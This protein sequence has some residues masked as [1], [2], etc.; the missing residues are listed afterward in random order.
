MTTHVVPLNEAIQAYDEARYDDAIERLAPLVSENP[1]DPQLRF[2]LANACREAGL[3][4]E[5]MHHFEEVLKLT[6]DQKL[7]FTAR[8][9]LAELGKGYRREVES[10]PTPTVPEIPQLVP[11]VASSPGY[12]A[13]WR[14]TPLIPTGKSSFFQRFSLRTKATLLAVA[15]GLIPIVAIGSLAYKFADNA[16]T[17]KVNQGQVD[18]AKT[19]SN[20][21]SLF[22]LERFGDIQALS[23][24]PAFT[25]PRMQKMITGTEKREFLESYMKYNSYYDSIVV[26]DLAG[27][28][29]LETGTGDLKSYK[30]SDYFQAVLKNSKPIISSPRRSRG[31]GKFSIYVAAPLIDTVTG[32]VIGVIRTRIPQENIQQFLTRVTDAHFFFVNAEGIIFS[33][34]D[35]KN[36]GQNLSEVVPGIGFLSKAKV[37]SSAVLMDKD[38]QSL[39]AY[40]PSIPQKG[41][42]E[43][44]WSTVVAVDTKTAYTAQNQLLFTLLVG[45]GLTALLVSITAATVANRAIVPIL[46]ATKAVQ[47]LGEGDL[48]VRL[49]V[50][51]EDEIALLGNNINGMAGQLQELLAKQEWV[52]QVAITESERQ[53]LLAT[54]GSAPAR[55]IEDL[56][57]VLNQLLAGPQKQLHLDRLVIYV[58]K[59]DGSGFVVAE[60]V[61]PGWPLAL[62]DTI[63]DRVQDPC[64]AQERIAFYRTGGVVANHNL[65]ESGYCEEHHQLL[66]RLKVKANLIVPLL[67]SG[68]VR[69]LL[70][71]HNCTKPHRWT[72]EEI[73]ELQLLAAQL[74]PITER[75]SYLEQ[76]DYSRALA[77]TVSEEQRAQTEALQMQLIT[78]LDEVEGAAQGDL[79]VRANVTAGE[80]GIVGD[81]FNAIIENLRKIVTQVKTS[82]ADL[83]TSLGD[84][85]GSMRSLAEDANRQADEISRTLGSVEYMTLSIQEVAQSARQAAIVAKN[86]SITAAEGGLSMD[87]TVAGILD[88]R[89]TVAETSKKVKRLGESSQKISK[90]VSLINQIALQT[91]V[92]AINASIEAAR[93][94]EEGRGFAVVA[95]EVGALATRS[96]AATREIEQL[97]ENIQSETSEVVDAMAT[98]TSQVVEGTRLVEE[99]K[100]SLKQIQEVS[101]QIDDLVGRISD[102]T[103]SQTQTSQAVTTL[104]KQI[105]A[106]AERSSEASA[107]VS[108]S[109]RQTVQV[110]QDL[111]R[112]V[113]YFKIP[114]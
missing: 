100:K 73:E 34:N 96:A 39:V 3:L 30:N 64:I 52:R 51:G 31:T 108:D 49:K 47:R 107:H 80:I 12:A 5:A 4:D 6:M 1:T 45:S 15:I 11:K 20:Q 59:L 112:S 93:A 26:M 27:R 2:W 16:F 92:L 78:L 48:N 28:P 105:A 40:S 113:A 36:L 114:Q 79:T 37:A 81:F 68:E 21:L 9:A 54:L 56:S 50:Q 88:L 71:A 53:K 65:Q 97:V 8:S 13:T 95:A 61:E 44:G 85:E 70:I 103:I 76:L 106:I 77:E 38:Q 66:D 43:L 23:T 55:S 46:S 18:Q 82:T 110:A 69:G 101:R 75:F 41:L 74:S 72:Q 84:N 58:F 24:S 10:E 102:T 17:Q 33:T 63:A 83:N 87:R 57:P 99:A 111:Q 91:N 104:M 19:L 62:G 32:K 67:G 109:L 60:S 35:T 25:D 42:A 89:E 29:V 22:M 86:A 90:V 94:G 98:G 14:G 7:I